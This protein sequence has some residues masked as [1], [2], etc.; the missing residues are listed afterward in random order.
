MIVKKRCFQQ[1]IAGERRC[2]DAMPQHH[3]AQ[4]QG[5]LPRTPLSDTLPM[6]GHAWPHARRSIGSVGQEASEAHTFLRR[7]TDCLRQSQRTPSFQP[8]AGSV[9]RH[10]AAISEAVTVGE[11]PHFVGYP[12]SC[13]CV[14]AWPETLPK[15][16]ATAAQC[17]VTASSAGAAQALAAP[18]LLQLHLAQ[19]A[20]ESCS[21][22]KGASSLMSD[23]SLCS[24][25]GS[26]WPLE[27]RACARAQLLAPPSSARRCP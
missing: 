1:L 7:P 12:A 14:C 2:P 15:S 8:F 4:R 23:S 18:R 24:V 27:T 16:L 26:T 6:H 20:A 10:R 9:L 22:S 5:I 21:P 17:G 13:L 11:R 19:L 3:D 25:H